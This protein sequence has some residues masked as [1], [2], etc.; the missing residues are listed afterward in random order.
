MG[1][2]G[3][4]DCLNSSPV[5]ET[6]GDER[7]DAGQMWSFTGFG[8]LPNDA[9]MGMV[10]TVPAGENAMHVS[11]N[12][13]VGGDCVGRL[14]EDTTVNE[15]AYPPPKNI[16]RAMAALPS[17][18]S[19]SVI[20]GQTNYA[21]GGAGNEILVVFMPGGSGAARFT[22]GGAGSSESKWVLA[23]GKKYLAEI[24]N[25]SGD[26]AQVSMMMTWY[27]APGTEQ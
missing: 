25:I 1:I 27:E 4:K 24:T 5:Q 2:P 11:F 22:P 3:L 15:V 16:N 14:Y 18:P 10:I 12:G 19:P 20:L 23:P 17:P 6:R 7:V 9:K 21:S 8:E 26:D 13:W